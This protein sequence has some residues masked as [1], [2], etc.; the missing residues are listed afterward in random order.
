MG[1]GAHPRPYRLTTWMEMRTIAVPLCQHWLEKGTRCLCPAMKGT[2]YC[3]SHRHE[4]ARDAKKNAER[5]RQTWFESAPL[6]DVPSVQRAIGQVMTRLLSGSISPKQAG[7]MLFKFQ[8]VSVNL[9]NEELGPRKE[10]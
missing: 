8:T 7:Q 6:D 1:G 3:F 5:A 10:K 2:R 4:Q 9:R